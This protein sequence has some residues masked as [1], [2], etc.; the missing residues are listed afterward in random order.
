MIVLGSHS[1]QEIV[2]REAKD[3]DL[4]GTLDEFR[5]YVG[6]RPTM[7]GEDHAYAETKGRI[8]DCELIWGEGLSLDLARLILTDP[9]TTFDDELQAWV[10]SLN[11]LYMLK[12]THRFKKNSP[13]FLKTMQD[14]HS[15]RM[16][17]AFMQ[18][19]HLEF[20]RARQKATLQYEHPN[21][22]RSKAEFFNPEDDYM[23]YDHDSIHVAIALFDEPAYTRYA[24]EGAEVL[25]SHEKFRAQPLN[26]QLAGVYEEACVL[27][28]ERH[29]IPNGFRPDP[30][31]SFEIALEKVCTSITS[32]W[33]RAFAWEN[34]H[35]VLDMDK[36]TEGCYRERFIANKDKLTIYEGNKK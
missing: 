36:R 18:E 11:V 23:V 17:K 7:I 22:N 2:G 33:F 1:V 24:V 30:R 27:A 14:I 34:Y 25:S 21:L 4:L 6:I 5:D 31:R 28:L 3:L 8:Y 9:N 13:H 10:P 12:L 16:A 26:N 29:L 35:K 15:M 32:G 19:E 20:F